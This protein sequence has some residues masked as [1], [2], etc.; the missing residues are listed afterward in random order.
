MVR[1]IINSYYT[2]L[3]VERE[4]KHTQVFIFIF[5]IYTGCCRKINFLNLCNVDYNLKFEKEREKVEERQKKVLIFFNFPYSFPYNFYTYSIYIK[6]L[7]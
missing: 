2:L 3:S 7:L 4:V 1:I 5:K 6:Y